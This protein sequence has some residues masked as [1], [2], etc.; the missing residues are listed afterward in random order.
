METIVLN[1][2]VRE[3]TGKS[4]VKPLR[5]KGVIPAVMYRDGKESINLSV[6]KSDLFD[7]L[8]TTAGANVL[9]TLKIK[10]DKK[11]KDRI[12]IIKEVQKNPLK[13]DIIHVDFNEISLTEKIKV[14]VPVR[15]RGDAEGVVK[16]GGVL[17]LVLWEVEVECLP[18]DIPG[19]I[20][21]EISHIKIGDA[22]YVKDLKVPEGVRVLSDPEL[23]V[24]TVMMP[25]KEELPEAVAPE[26]IEEP[27][28]ISKGKKEEEEIPEEEEKPEKGESPS[29]GEKKE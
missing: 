7:V 22:V 6:D 17:D 5:K 1:A 19:K 3:E 24:L 14:K 11:K 20:E 26:G 29:K 15:T 27:E 16:D 21:V 25:A 4:K 8:H 9:V 10:G 28:V 18:T 12:C 13:E 23:T 2:E